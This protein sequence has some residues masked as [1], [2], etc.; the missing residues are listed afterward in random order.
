MQNGTQSRIAYSQYVSDRKGGP[1][2]KTGIIICTLLFIVTAIALPCTLSA[3][4]SWSTKLS[5]PTA[6]YDMA[7]GMVGDVIYVIG[8]DPG[9]LVPISTV[10]AYDPGP[11]ETWTAKTDMPYNMHRLAAA[12]IGAKIYTCGG[13]YGMGAKPYTFE[14]DPG[15]NS[16]T[17]NADMP[18]ARIFHAAASYN[19][20]MYAF[21][22][23][24]TY[25][26][27][28]EYEPTSDSWATK[29]PMPTGRYG[30][31][32][33]T[34]NG[35]IYVIGGQDGTTIFS[36]VEEYDPIADSWI[37]KTPMPTPRA[38]LTACVVRDTIYA[39]GGNDN[40]KAYLNTVEKYD[41]ATDNWT[42]DTPMPTARRAPISSVVNDIIYV[43]GGD[44]GDE[45]DVNEAAEP[46]TGIELTSFN[47]IGEKGG[48]LL[49]WSTSLETGIVCWIIE[50]CVGGPY[51]TI[52]TLDGKMQSPSPTTYRFFDDG[53]RIGISNLYRLGAQCTDNSTRWYGP[54]S[55]TPIACN[56]ITIQISPNPFSTTTTISFSRTGQSAEGIEIQIIDVTGRRVRDFILYPSSF[57]LPAKLEWDGRD[58]NGRALPPGIY[59]LTLKTNSGT[60]KTVKKITLIK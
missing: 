39:I 42:S 46:A 37:T 20:K 47:A 36:T 41:P 3:A 19:G 38:Y 44:N 1:L 29:T 15:L 53:A 59:F 54:V 5:M 56:D 35:K 34:V 6:R 33:V 57:I 12:V 13:W 40:T 52:T 2:K 50:R 28:Y 18:A 58:E 24:Y 26:T 4:L 10:E 9:N 23:R 25:N 17:Q 31:A 21:G 7:V 11:L 48:V 43:I 55:A 32:A 49:S 27:V 60:N 8:G 30:H 51:E 45:L 22:G 16:W 14:Y